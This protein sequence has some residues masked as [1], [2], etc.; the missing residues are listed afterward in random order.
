MAQLMIDVILNCAKTRPVATF[1]AFVALHAALWT[2]LPAAFYTAPPLDVV[3]LLAW[4]HEWQLG[5]FKHPPMAAWVI[6]AGYQVFGGVWSAYLLSQLSIAATFVAVWLLA[7]PMV[8]ALGALVA[9]VALEGIFYF[10]VPTPE[11]NNNVLQMPLWAWSI[12]LFYRALTRASLGHWLGLGAVLAALFYTKYSGGLLIPV[13]L[14]IM[15]ASYNGRAALF[16]RGPWIGAALGLFLALPHMIWSAGSDL[17]AVDYIFAQDRAETLLGRFGNAL[18]FVLAQGLDHLPLAIVAGVAVL[19]WRTGKSANDRALLVPLPTQDR[20]DRFFVLAVALG[21]VL[22]AAALSFIIN[23]RFR[24]MW[25]TPMFAFSGLALVMLARRALII[26]RPRLC[27]AIMAAL[28][29]AVPVVHT[30]GLWLSP[31]ITHKGHRV[32]WP[33]EEIGEAVRAAWT[34]ETGGAAAG[35]P[36]T[37]LAGN[38]WLAG[39]AALYGEGRPSVMLEGNFAYSPWISPQELEQEGGVVLWQVRGPGE[40][41]MPAIY[42]DAGRLALSPGEP[43]RFSWPGGLPVKEIVIGWAIIPPGGGAA[44]AAATPRD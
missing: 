3:E 38:S 41:A 26:H 35:H 42:A 15:L 11:F 2:L 40:G 18:G 16:T 13:F 12:L 9:V 36:L 5:Y 24:S 43:M 37:I 32:L 14:L 33:G 25:G 30:A 8:G 34:R 39:L 10:T 6:E 28:V 20:F 44:S 21:P 27:A 1:W 31:Y 17:A 29:V 7:R 23:V 22:L 19:G 4:G